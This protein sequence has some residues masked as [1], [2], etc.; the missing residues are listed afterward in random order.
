MLALLAVHTGAVAREDPPASAPSS[1]AHL[2]GVA[3]PA[4][5]V[6]GAPAAEPAGVGQVDPKLVRLRFDWP[7]STEVQ[8]TQRRTRTRTGHAPVT[9]TTRFT[10]RLE[11]REGTLRISTSGTTWEGDA[12]YPGSPAAVEGVLR[13]AERVMQ[14]VSPEGEFRGL[15]GVEALRPALSRVLEGS[16]PPEQLERALTFAEASMQLQAQEMWNLA[17]GFWIGAD[18]E[19]GE[20]YV[21]RT[22][23]EVPLAQ[24]LAEFEQEF[25]VRR[26]VPCSARDHDERCVEVTLRSA[27]DPA[28]LPALAR[29][30]VA[31]LAPE[32]SGA[33]EA[34]RGLVME[35]ELLLV[36]EPARLLPHRVV[37]TRTIRG[38]LGAAEG[39]GGEPRLL[40]QVDRH[41]AD[42]R[43]DAP[44]KKPPRK[45][46][47]A[48]P[49]SASR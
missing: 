17:V 38:T 46:K 39:A 3:A 31:Q 14:V 20:R 11:R 18:L 16:V 28:A 30:V 49:R 37:W 15:E 29:G 12:P 1:P 34:L 2:P 8:A 32:A 7:A 22:E 10:Q 5:P 4:S 19:L 48:A 26:R 33:V 45:P 41:E 40:E 21:M 13:A 43:Y 36:T 27:P 23:A 35:N 9:T 6:P 25:S 24:T 42:Y 44:R 47:R